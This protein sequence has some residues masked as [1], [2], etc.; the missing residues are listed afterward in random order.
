M[1]AKKR[2]V[3]EGGYVER[4]RKRRPRKREKALRHHYVFFRKSV[5]LS[6]HPAS[7]K[8]FELG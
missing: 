6:F 7:P 4:E 1:I 3:G 2:G 5:L 8:R